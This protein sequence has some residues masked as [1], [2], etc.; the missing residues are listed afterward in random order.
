MPQKVRK[1]VEGSRVEGHV[2]IAYLGA[3]PDEEF[4]WALPESLRIHDAQSL[5]LFRSG[6]NSHA[7]ARALECLEKEV[8]YGSSMGAQYCAGALVWARVAAP[9]TWWP[10]RV[11][12][13]Q[14][15]SREHRR[16]LERDRAHMSKKSARVVSLLGEGAFNWFSAEDL[17]PFDGEHCAELT[18]Q[19]GENAQA[20]VEAAAPF[21]PPWGESDSDT[22]ESRG[23]SPIRLSRSPRTPKAPRAPRSA[24]QERNG[25]TPDWVVDAGCAIFGLH[26]EGTIKGLLD[27]CCND[28]EKPNI[29]AERLYDKRD[30][31]LLK[32]NEWKGF[33]VILNPPYEPQTQW[34]FI[35]RAIN[36]V[37][38]GNV[39]GALIVCRNSTDTGYFQRLRP[40]LRVMLRRDA[41][42]FKD[43][44]SSP[45]GFGICVF[46]LAKAPEHRALYY[47]R[48][49][50]QF[51][52]K[53]EINTVVDLE[54]VRSLQFENLVSR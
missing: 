17:K 19:M 21:R 53:G 34:R 4:C 46:V 7:G 3:D 37:E 8:A 45:I 16:A 1:V 25:L 27:P 29:P 33:H 44:D 49:V 32:K 22:D 6:L 30:D 52:S 51:A 47:P 54:F 12:K 15:T 23:G 42:R 2:L 5:E 18:S 50:E 38:F 11:W 48:F 43:Y 24:A 40:Y 26:N 13:I 41:I 10:G 35:N 9:G 14:H 39:P 36:E 28:K 31:G 20:L